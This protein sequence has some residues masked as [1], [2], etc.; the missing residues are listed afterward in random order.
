[1]YSVQINSEILWCISDILDNVL[2]QK[3]LVVEQNRPQFRGSVQ[4]QS[5][6]I[7]Y[8]SDCQPCTSKTDGSRAKGLKIWASGETYLVH[9]GYF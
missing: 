1:M 5:E 7:P 6:V 4:G 9:M 2:S 8:I 3:R